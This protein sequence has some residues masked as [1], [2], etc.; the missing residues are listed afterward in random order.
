M[1]S[2]LCGF[3]DGEEDGVVDTKYK[4]GNFYSTLMTEAVNQSVFLA[5][6]A[7]NQYW[8]RTGMPFAFSGIG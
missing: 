8:Y 1:C 6:A 2:L 3:S 5:E 7:A 4:C